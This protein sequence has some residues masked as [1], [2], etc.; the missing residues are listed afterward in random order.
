MCKE[1]VL[2]IEAA[3]YQGTG[4]SQSVRASSLYDGISTE[5]AVRYVNYWILSCVALS[6]IQQ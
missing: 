1:V 4:S 2:Y 5:Q 6:S 3:R